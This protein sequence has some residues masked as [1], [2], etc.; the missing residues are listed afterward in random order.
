MPSLYHQALQMFPEPVAPDWRTQS[1][2][3]A[4]TSKWTL[5]SGP[6]IWRMRPCPN[7]TKD[8]QVF[9]DEEDKHKL[10]W[11]MKQLN[12]KAILSHLVWPPSSTRRRTSLLGIV[13]TL[14]SDA[15]ETTSKTHKH[16]TLLVIQQSI[17]WSWLKTRLHSTHIIKSI[18]LNN[19]TSLTC[20]RVKMH[21][22]LFFEYFSLEK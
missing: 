16:L 14:F 9:L 6:S 12:R 2:H 18:R 5:K 11:W 17:D 1:C 4:E 15:W 21:D 13:R 20:G 22:K 19:N 3:T 10:N 8:A 7:Q